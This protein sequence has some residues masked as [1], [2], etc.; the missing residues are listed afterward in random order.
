MKNLASLNC[1]LP[2]IKKS[3]NSFSSEDASKPFKK[4]FR[5]DVQHPHSK[6]YWGK[7]SKEYRRNSME[8]AEN[9]R[10]NIQRGRYQQYE[11][12]TGLQRRRT[13]RYSDA[14]E[15]TDHPH[16]PGHYDAILQVEDNLGYLDLN[17]SGF[18][19]DN[20]GK[21]RH[22]YPQR[23]V[24]ERL[25]FQEYMRLTK[26]AETTDPNA[27]KLLITNNDESL[28]RKL[29]SSYLA[30]PAEAEKRVVEWKEAVPSTTTGNRNIGRLQTTHEGSFPI[31][32]VSPISP[33]QVRNIPKATGVRA[34]VPGRKTNANLELS[35]RVVSPQSFKDN[36]KMY[37]Y[38][39]SDDSEEEE[40]SRNWN[41]SISTIS[42]VSRHVQ[43][44]E[45][46]IESI[47]SVEHLQHPQVKPRPRSFEPEFQKPSMTR[48][49]T[50]NHSDR[51]NK[52]IESP[53]R[54]QYYR[55]YNQRKPRKS[56]EWV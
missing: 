53:Q 47:V 48:L 34:L 41:D 23:R 25:L 2:S 27:K 13:A 15:E 7:V 39:D 45:R 44:N 21:N 42:C 32:S 18:T 55:R 17:L 16:D 14:W 31:R 3:T 40:D 33:K 28:G 29:K 10:P 50:A 11:R 51:Y 54:A 30:L 36:G 22:S 37:S 24:N 12:Q 4:S 9:M 19:V 6:E 52:V 35:M 43:M 20:R 8:E 38:A 49:Q 26:I 56:L 5:T 1:I 46:N